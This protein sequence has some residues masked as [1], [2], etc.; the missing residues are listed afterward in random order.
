MVIEAGTLNHAYIL[1][2][3][4]EEKWCMGQIDESWLWNR[5]MG[6]M[7]FENMVKISKRK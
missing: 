7:S 5:R 6:H 2:Q 1:I 4:K 3:I